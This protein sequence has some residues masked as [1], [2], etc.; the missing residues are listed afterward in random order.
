MTKKKNLERALQNSRQLS[1]MFNS[2]HRNISTLRIF[3]T[4]SFLRHT[5][6]ETSMDMILQVL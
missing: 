6:L 3:L 5:I 4:Q 1:R 2:G